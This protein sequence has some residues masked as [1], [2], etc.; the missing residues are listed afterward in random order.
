MFKGKR[1]TPAMIV[2]MIALAV[3]LSGTAVAGTAKL[4]TGSQIANGTIKL[5]DLHQSAKA[6]LKGKRG[7]TGAQGPAGAQG[8]QG[9]AGPQGATGAKGDAGLKGD[10][11]TAEGRQGWQGRQ[12]R[13][14]RTRSTA[15]LH[16]RVQR[17]T[18]GQTPWAT[19]STELGSPVGDTTG[20]SFRFTCSSAQEPCMVS[21]VAK[22]LS[23]HERRVRQRSTRGVLDLPTHGDHGQLATRPSLIRA[24]TATARC[25]RR[26]RGCR[27]IGIR[28]AGCPGARCTSAARA[29]CNG[30][31]PAAAGS[32][33]TRSWCRRADYDVFST[34][35]FADGLRPV[36][37][38]EKR[39]GPER[40]R[41]SVVWPTASSPDDRGSRA[42]APGGTSPCPSRATPPRRP[43]PQRT[44]A[45][46]VLSPDRLRS[47]DARRRSCGDARPRRR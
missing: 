1:F 15:S 47:R 25:R 38:I 3:A 32:R 4:I 14:R 20:G 9:L 42:G 27:S 21:V 28:D 43:L 35:V 8:A 16:V 44:P 34:L 41:P 46:S 39:G 24:S 26:S 7:A 22:V 23:R 18:G 5:A 36:A 30:T 31:G 12:G 11:G 37:P 13:R 45:P 17:G 6:A 29:D 19:Y 40:S 10:P 2:A 33:S